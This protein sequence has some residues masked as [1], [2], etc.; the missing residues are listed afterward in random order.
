[1]KFKYLPDEYL[2]RINIE[3]LCGKIVTSRKCMVLCDRPYT[4]QRFP[5][6]LFKLNEPMNLGNVAL[7]NIILGT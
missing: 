7:I 3:L 2:S 6:I 1:M 5:N 4:F